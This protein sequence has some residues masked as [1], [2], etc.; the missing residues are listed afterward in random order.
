MESKIS[1]KLTR[2]QFR[3][4]VSAIVA[5]DSEMISDY[6]K[7]FMARAL[8]TKLLKR[9]I[10]RLDGLSP[11]ATLSMNISEAVAFKIVML[12]NFPL[13]DDYQQSILNP[14]ILRIDQTLC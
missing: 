12:A 13:F 8:L 9:M 2:K 5:S 6:E 14:M 3:A 7:A 1:F 11:M 10:N 4:L